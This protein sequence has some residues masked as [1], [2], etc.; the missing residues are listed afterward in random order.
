M[1]FLGEC[2]HKSTAQRY[3]TSTWVL[4]EV[5]LSIQKDYKVLDIIEVYEYELTKYDRHTREGGLLA[6]YINTFLTLKAEA[7]GY[8]A[9]V[10]NP[11]EEE[12]YLETF[13]PFSARGPIYRP[14]LC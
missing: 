9:W 10:R 1:Q 13:N 2:V 3:L 6:D 11:E 8:P 12:S 5:Q 14:P 4:D 7:R